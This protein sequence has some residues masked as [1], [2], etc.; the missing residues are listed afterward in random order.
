MESPFRATCPDDLKVIETLGAGPDG[1]AGWPAHRARM[2]ATLGRLG[3]KADLDA[4]DAAVGALRL[5]GPS[6]VRLTVDL[7]GEF[8]VQ[9]FPA[10]PTPDVWHIALSPVVVDAADPWFSVKTT[11]R[12][13]YDRARATLPDGVDELIFVNQAGHVTEG[14]ITN[15]FVEIDE[16]LRTPPVSDGVLPG[17]L[18]GKLIA[19]GRAEVGHVTWEDVLASPRV[20]VGNALRG[21]I[22]ARSAT[23]A[24]E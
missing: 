24:L 20:Y 10:G 16:I 23:V 21:L 7:A 15:I 3:I 5:A 13:L 14:T 19:D 4:I 1:A 12:A 11:Q 22:K 18:R 9:T 8:N 2:I 17:V 6:R